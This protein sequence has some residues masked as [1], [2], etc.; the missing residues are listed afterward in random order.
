MK[1]CH[2]HNN[3]KVAGHPVLWDSR[4]FDGVQAEKG[5][6]TYASVLQ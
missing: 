6:E 5:A 3:Y 1:N 2:E 4:F